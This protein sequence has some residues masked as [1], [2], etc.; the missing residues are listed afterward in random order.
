ML[1]SVLPQ[2]FS[3]LKLRRYTALLIT[4]LLKLN[5]ILAMH[6]N[7]SKIHLVIS[8]NLLGLWVEIQLQWHPFQAC[9]TF[10]KIIS[11]MYQIKNMYVFASQ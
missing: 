10:F 6:K 9:I 2:T 4:K 8:P 5:K 7:S 11:E 1:L 3:S